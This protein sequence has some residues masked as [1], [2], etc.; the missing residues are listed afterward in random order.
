[1]FSGTNIKRNT[2]P[3]PG[4]D[5]EFQGDECLGLGIRLDA[6]NV[7]IPSELAADDIFGTE[8]SDALEDFDAFVAEVFEVD[9]GW[10]LHGDVTEYL[11]QVVL[12][13]IA[14]GPD[15]IVE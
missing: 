5:T 6:R 3:T 14:D 13:D 7:V 8:R 4:I 15:A 2:L 12:D 9:A 10:W 1:M 11:H